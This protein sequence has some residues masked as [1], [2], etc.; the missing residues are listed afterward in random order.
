MR[1]TCQ[2]KIFERASE[3]SVIYWMRESRGLGDLLDDGRARADGGAFSREK[4]RGEELAH[5]GAAGELMD[6]RHLLPTPILGVQR[7]RCRPELETTGF[8]F[9]QWHHVVAGQERVA[10]A[11][12]GCA[13]AH[14]A[15]RPQLEG[16]RGPNVAAADWLLS[17][18]QAF[19]CKTRRA[20]SLGREPAHP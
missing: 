10:P 11:A 1:R 18:L 15:L 2:V 19:L 13:A 14:L 5:L 3:D 17:V 9:H 12:R 4:R 7:H 8:L 20:A 6:P 16:G